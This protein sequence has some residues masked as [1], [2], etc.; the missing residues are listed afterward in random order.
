[1]IWF[2]ILL[3]VLFGLKS[4]GY[5]AL[6]SGWVPRGVGPGTFACHAVVHA[7][8]AIGVAIWLL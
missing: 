5:L 3:I 2:A 7:L 6:V 8:L 1:M 4:I